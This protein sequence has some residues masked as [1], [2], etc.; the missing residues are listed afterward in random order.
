MRMRPLFRVCPL[1]FSGRRLCLIYKAKPPINRMT[2]IRLIYHL[3]IRFIDG[4]LRR[5]LPEAER[6]LFASI[7]GQIAY[8]NRKNHGFRVDNYKV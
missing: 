5:R 4:R 2:A 1:Y 6:I 7:I 8:Y 3:S